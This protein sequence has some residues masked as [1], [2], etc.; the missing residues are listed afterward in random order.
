MRRINSKLIMSVCGIL[1]G[2]TM[3]VTAS[4]AWLTVSV[5]PEL[6]GLVIQ[7]IPNGKEIPFEFSINYDGTDPDSATWT[8]ELHLDELTEEMV[9]RPISTVDGVNWYLPRYSAAG[10]VNGFWKADLDYCANADPDSNYLVYADV[11]VRTRNEN[12][13]QEMVLS[14]PSLK[15]GGGYNIMASEKFYG[16]YALWEPMKKDGAWVENDA[17]ASLR[18]GLLFT[19]EGSNSGSG[20]YI[21]EPNADM[22]STDFVSW[23]AGTPDADQMKDLEYTYTQEDSGQ[24]ANIVE[25][26][27][28]RYKPEDKP[29]KY[30]PTWVPKSTGGDNWTLVNVNETLGNRVIA[31]KTSKWNMDKLTE[32]NLDS[33]AIGTIGALC[34]VKADGSLEEMAT[35]NTMTTV[36]Y[37]TIQ[38]M[39]IF[40]WLEGQD[41]DCWNQIAEGNL[42]VNLEFMGREVE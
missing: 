28:T 32:N 17:M 1:L 27:E 35:S 13:D 30:Y 31:Q 3:L 10:D 42:Y 40:I 39:R 29:G 14:K 41:V 5:K 9:L 16:S 19:E 36:E 4:Y 21:Y 12:L 18:V 2:V 7:I 23:L 20:F 33:E 37:E 22:R 38:K 8:T 24:A 25:E 11:W 15:Q 6:R 26:Y 34:K